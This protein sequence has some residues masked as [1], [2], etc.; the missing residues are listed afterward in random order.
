MTATTKG[1]AAM[2]LVSCGRHCGMGGGDGIIPGIRDTCAWTGL[3]EMVAADAVKAVEMPRGIRVLTDVSVEIDSETREI[4]VVDAD[5]VPVCYNTGYPRQR[6]PLPILEVEIP[7]SVRPNQTFALAIAGH[8]T[9]ILRAPLIIPAGAPGFGAPRRGTMLIHV[10]P[11]EMAVLDSSY[12]TL[13]SR[14]LPV[15]P[16]VPRWTST[17]PG[18]TSAGAARRVP[19]LTEA[20][21]EWEG[22][23]PL[24]V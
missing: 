24:P 16:P 6:P 2:R 11:R 19:T 23:A 12:E 15:L 18:G 4:R 7:D 8:G 13:V 3:E 10:P 14:V 21:A 9:V 22:G 1:C 20:L 17:A 5:G